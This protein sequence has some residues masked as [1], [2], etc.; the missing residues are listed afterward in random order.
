MQSS[1]N[2][3]PPAPRRL[4]LAPGLLLVSVGLLALVSFVPALRELVH[5]LGRAANLHVWYL[6]RMSGLLAYYLLWAGTV[7]GLLVSGRRLKQ[8]QRVQQ[9]TDWHTRF[10]LWALYVGT[11][12]GF[13]LL[14]DEYVGFHI[15]QIVVPF[16]GKYHPFLM[17]LGSLG[18]YIALLLV[19]TSLVRHRL[20]LRLWRRLHLLSFPLYLMLTLHAGLLGTDAASDWAQWAMWIAGFVVIALTLERFNARY[21]EGPEDEDEDEEEA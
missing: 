14:W 19:V 15:L 5:D 16:F 12:H 2:F 4:R 13:V 17:G 7:A 8:P 1:S 11:F 10:T 9:A 20:G 21:K 3:T 18:L 6:A